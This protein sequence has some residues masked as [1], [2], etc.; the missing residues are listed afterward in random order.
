[1]SVLACGFYTG[2]ALGKLVVGPSG[3][4]L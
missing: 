2:P 4:L 3:P 1:M